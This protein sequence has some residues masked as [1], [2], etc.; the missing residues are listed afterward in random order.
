M[1]IKYGSG[2]GSGWG[3]GDGGGEG[4]F[5]NKPSPQQLLKLKGK[6]LEQLLWIKRGYE[7]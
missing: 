6:T 4:Y 3:S 5:E 1:K 2:S 7:L